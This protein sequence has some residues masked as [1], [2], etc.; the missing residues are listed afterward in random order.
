M[1]PYPPEKPPWN[2]CTTEEKDYDRE[3]WRG[4]SNK[5]G[6]FSKRE[7]TGILI[8]RWKGSCCIPPELVNS[9]T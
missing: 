1:P 9:V 3:R 8:R 6:V 4:S 7:V 2:S 5:F